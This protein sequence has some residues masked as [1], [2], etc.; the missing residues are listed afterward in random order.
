MP[1]TVSDGVPSHA[2]EA[3][4][5]SHGRVSGSMPTASITGAAVCWARSSG[6]TRMRSTGRLAERLAE[7][8]GLLEAD[9]GEAGVL[10]GASVPVPLGLAVADEDELHAG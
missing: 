4:S 9:V 2:G 1:S 5:A 8:R 7:Q 3:I 6:E 10:D